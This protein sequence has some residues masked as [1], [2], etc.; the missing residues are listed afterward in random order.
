MK[1]P[2][3][4]TLETD[5]LVLRRIRESDCE[6][7]FH[8]WAEKEEC[9]RYFPWNPVRDI[10]TY[11]RKVLFWIAQYE[12]PSYFQWV[13]ENKNSGE[14]IGIINLHDVDEVRNIAETSYILS[15]SCWGQG[16]MTEALQCVLQFAFE[17]AALERVRADVF[18]G[19]AA[20]ERVLQKC[21]MVREGILKGKYLKN[22]KSI[23]A[24]LYEVSRKR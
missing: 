19:N 17:E 14:L 1:K 22:G 21:G 20:S 18:E 6:A 24:V 5:R 2:G 23:D 11:Q 16:I 4:K 7:M 8:N 10:N 9:S 13:I 3:T 15:P 12:D